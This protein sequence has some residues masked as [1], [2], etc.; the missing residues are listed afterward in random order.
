MIYNPVMDEL[1]TA[2][3]GGGA[4]LNDKKR[5][6]VA[7]PQASGRRSD[8][9]RHQAR[10]A[11]PTTCCSCGN[12]AQI[13]PAVAGIRRTGSASTDL[14]WLAAGR[15]DGYW[16]ARLAPWD[17]APGSLM[18]RK[19]AAP[20]PIM[21]AAPGTFWNGQVDR[22]Q[23]DHP[24]PAAQDRSRAVEIAPGNAAIPPLHVLAAKPLSR[25]N[26]VTRVPGATGRIRPGTM[27]QTYD[28]VPSEEPDDLP[29]EDRGL[30]GDRGAGDRDPLPASDHLLLGQPVHQQPDHPRRR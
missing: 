24:G 8:L 14:A 16:E 13:N 1:F 29:R 10:T 12:S 15:F 9:D 3:K 11:A 18:V 30:S 19:P 21:P 6:R 23:R 2:E 7:G 5:L 28:P 26:G 20:S 25:R 22:R 4:W 27:S 17:V